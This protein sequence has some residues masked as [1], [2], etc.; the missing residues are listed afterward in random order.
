MSWRCCK[1]TD[2]R[3]KINCQIIFRIFKRS[4]NTSSF[5]PAVKMAPS[6]AGEFA[7]VL[8]VSGC[9]QRPGV[10]PV[11][12]RGAEQSWAGSGGVGM[13]VGCPWGARGGGTNLLP[14][15]NHWWSLVPPAQWGGAHFPRFGGSASGGTHGG[16]AIPIPAL[17]GPSPWDAE[18]R[19]L[20]ALFPPGQSRAPAQQWGHLQGWA[21]GCPPH[22]VLPHTGE[23]RVPNIF[24][25]TLH[26][27]NQG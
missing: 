1:D 7:F 10:A 2:S 20:R 21:R 16:T 19:P 8:L 25:L 3:N 4:K 11:A 22:P 26:T 17:V 23:P 5:S 13:A 15:R 6:A 14:Q 9:G 27:N 18:F 12:K 24:K